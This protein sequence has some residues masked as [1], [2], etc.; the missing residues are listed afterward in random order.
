MPTLF[1]HVGTHKTGTTTLQHVLEQKLDRARYNLVLPSRYRGTEFDRLWRSGASADFV[2]IFAQEFLDG[3]DC[4]ISE[5]RLLGL[6]LVNGFYGGRHKLAELL[7]GLRARGYDLRPLIVLRNA[8]DFFKS[9]YLQT[10][11]TGYTRQD[12][13]PF[14]GKSGII[15]PG[16]A[17]FLQD[18]EVAGPFQVVPYEM[19]LGDS[20]AF[21]AHLNTWLQVDVFGPQDFHKRE[22]I[23]VTADGMAVLKLVNGLPEVQK[24]KLVR[25]VRSEFQDGPAATVVPA[26]M[27]TILR[28]HF[29][30]YEKAFCAARMPFADA[31]RFWLGA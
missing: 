22:N 31:E 24:R 29:W 26:N 16:Y 11:G 28:H 8:F 13:L 27:E 30:N 17:D 2:R 25:F 1:V 23:S 18:L 12:F 7:Q 5:E 15:S 19:M 3:R 20:P 21:C 9:W 4:V 10:V 14:F 6:P